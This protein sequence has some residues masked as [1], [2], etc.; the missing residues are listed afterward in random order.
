[1]MRRLSPDIDIFARSKLTLGG[2]DLT[3][4]A[5]EGQLLG[6]RERQSELD[7]APPNSRPLYGIAH[8]GRALA[9]GSGKLLTLGN[10][11]WMV[12]VTALASST[13]QRVGIQS[14]IVKALAR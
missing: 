3:E 2:T 11:Q 8:V 12:C 9:I 13:R 5:R 1:M 14:G 10:D 7:A 6:R 4:A